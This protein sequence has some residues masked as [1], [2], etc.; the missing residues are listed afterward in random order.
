MK[1]LHWL[2]GIIVGFE[3]PV[4][5]YW[6]VLHGPIAFWRRHVRAGYWI[7]IILAWGGGDWL[8][9]HFRRDLFDWRRGSTSPW[10]IAA[11]VA[12]IAMD[13]FTLTVVEM[14]LGARRLVGQSELTDSG[15]LT[16]GGLY[17]HIRH[18]RYLGMMAGVLGVCV[19]AGTRALWLVSALWCVTALAV[20]QLEERELRSRFGSAYANY[21]LRVPALLPFRLRAHRGRI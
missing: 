4:P 2:A 1:A 20:I 8:L 12:L 21:A 18:P 15:E 9:Y 16:T 5:V 11:G 19:L 10:G 7:A 14:E 6:L 17:R 13:V 3:M